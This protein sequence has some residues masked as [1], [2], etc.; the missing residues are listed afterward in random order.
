MYGLGM[1]VFFSTCILEVDTT[2]NCHLQYAP[3]GWTTTLADLDYV[4]PKFLQDSPAF[5]AV[6]LPI[7]IELEDNVDLPSYSSHYQKKPP[8]LPTPIYDLSNL[9]PPEYSINLKDLDKQELIQRLY[10]LEHAPN[11]GTGKVFS[12]PVPHKCT[13]HD[14]II[15][16]LHHPNSILPPIPPCDM[17]NPPDTKSH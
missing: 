4:Q 11:F 1:C 17:S 2:T 6:P 8:M 10:L 3:L 14:N 12:A 9:L 13:T 7:T 15:N 16:K 5:A